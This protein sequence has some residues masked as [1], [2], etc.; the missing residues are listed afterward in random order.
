[1]K[2]ILGQRPDWRRPL[3]PWFDMD[4]AEIVAP[5]ASSEA[6]FSGFMEKWRLAVE[7][8]KMITRGRLAIHLQKASQLSKEWG[9]GHIMSRNIFDFIKLSA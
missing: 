5:G 6:A 9:G 4:R 3:W 7:T 2:S 8:D 1:M